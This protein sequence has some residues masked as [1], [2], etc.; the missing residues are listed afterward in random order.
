M[1]DCKLYSS[2]FSQLNNMN[3]FFRAKDIWFMRMFLQNGIAFYAT[4]ISIAS[5]LNFAVYISWRLGVDNT[6]A[7]TGAL[8][9]I[10][11]AIIV[12]FI[13]ENFVWRH[14]L[15]Y[16]FSPWIVIVIALIG[17][18]TKNWVSSSPSRNN[19]ISL[20][21][22]IIVIFLIIARIIIFILYKTVLKHKF[23]SFRAVAV[24]DDSQL[25]NGHLKDEKN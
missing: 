21:M 16:T 4:W 18:I 1:K 24:S 23:I 7:G 8:I 17:S 10:L 6:N 11:S 5:N 3:Q 2:Y 12:Y 14:Y 20:A 22:I 19:I 9:L 15:I 25:K 13:L